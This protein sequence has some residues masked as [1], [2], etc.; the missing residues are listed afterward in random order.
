MADCI[1][2]LKY[3]IFALIPFVFVNCQSSILQTGY[4]ENQEKKNWT[5]MVYMCGDN[6]LALNVLEDIN[7]MES[8]MRY[9]S[10]VNVIVLADVSSDY[11]SPEYSG[12][13]LYEISSDE[14]GMDYNIVSKE[15]SC[16]TLGLNKNI[17]NNLNLSDPK[18]LEDY[19]RFVKN[20]YPAEHY[21]FIMWG[22]G[23]GWRGE[24]SIGYDAFNNGRKKTSEKSVSR[25][26]AFDDTLK[27]YM[28]ISSFRNAL[29]K[30]MENSVIEYVGFDCCFGAELEVLYELKDSCKY[31]SG[32]EGIE[33]SNGWNY[34]LF[35]KNW[36]S[37]S[38][39]TGKGLCNAFYKMCSKN[40]ESR[41]Q[42]QSYN[43]NYIKL[44][45]NSFEMF[46]KRAVSEID[47][48]KISADDCVN[49]VKHYSVP[50]VYSDL[51]LN[52]FDLCNFLTSTVD[53]NDLLDDL[54][55]LKKNIEKTV[56]SLP[57]MKTENVSEN[58]VDGSSENNSTQNEFFMSPGVYFC[59]LDNNASIVKS[60][61]AYYING[62]NLSGQNDFVRDSKYYVPTKKGSVS[63]LDKIYKSIN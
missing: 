31:F 27:Q 42:Y 23:D 50:G 55:N 26:V 43:M 63:F 39:K 1:K 52:V 36:N 35:F 46:F 17:R 29:E 40:V 47:F 28:P 16:Q 51:Y 30:G 59:S 32:V 56:V 5:L 48:S 44:V 57:A 41:N 6:N 9:L 4:I 38:V 11:V 54:N 33:S 49:S 7:E 12:T 24:T 21:G 2:F 37:D 20:K 19:I 25:A 3:I 13:K 53:S 8:G 22:H 15:V 60:V 61:S 58:S 10:D 18:V 45:F 62:E 14:N 34:E